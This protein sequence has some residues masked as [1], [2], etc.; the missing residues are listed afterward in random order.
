MDFAPF[1]VI[2]PAVGRYEDAPMNTVHIPAR[3]RNKPDAPKFLTYVLRADVQ[4]ALN[5]AML[6]IPVNT[7]A[8]VAD[9]RFLI[10]GRRLL[11]EADGLSQFFDRDTD[12]ELAQVAMKGF[13]EFMLKPSRIDSIL[14]TIERTRARMHGAVRAQAKAR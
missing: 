2:D 9:D 6:Q 3:A 10:A 14:G 11:T 4:E 8:A 13:Q 7:R 5:R 1:P 12:E